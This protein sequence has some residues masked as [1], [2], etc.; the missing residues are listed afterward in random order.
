MSIENKNP[1]IETESDATLPP[2]LSIATGELRNRIQ[3]RVDHFTKWSKFWTTIYNLFLYL[4]LFASASA[5]II[6]KLEGLKGHTVMGFVQTDA[7]AI[8]AAVATFGSVLIASG[9]VSRKW[10]ANLIARRSAEELLLDLDDVHTRADLEKA[11]KQLKEIIRKQ[12]E[13]ILGL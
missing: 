4:S 1:K 2:D 6:L 12:N 13:G 10:R 8:L 9:G 7:A 11:K 3:E 5:A